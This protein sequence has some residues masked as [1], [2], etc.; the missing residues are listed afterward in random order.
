MIIIANFLIKEG[1]MPLLM[2]KKN[3]QNFQINSELRNNF[4]NIK[5]KRNCGSN[6]NIHIYDN[7]NNI[8]F[9]M[10]EVDAKSPKYNNFKIEEEKEEDNEIETEIEFETKP[11]TF[12]DKN[13][14]QNDL[15][16]KTL[17]DN[18]NEKEEDDLFL[19]IKDI[20]DT[21]EDENNNES[22]KNLSKYNINNN[23]LNQY[24]Y[25]NKFKKAQDLYE[26]NDSSSNL[27]DEIMDDFNIQKEKKFHRQSGRNSTHISNKKKSLL[28]KLRNKSSPKDFYKI[29]KSMFN[30]E[31]FLNSLKKY[32]HNTC[33][34]KLFD[35]IKMPQSKDMEYLEKEHKFLIETKPSKKIDELK[36]GSG[37]YH[38]YIFMIL[39][40]IFSAMILI[41][42]NL[43]LMSIF[44][45]A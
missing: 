12:S 16:F 14:F 42:L 23:K 2:K 20:K 13:A 44:Y 19:D 29:I 17:Y 8:N 36:L 45:N 28:F 43:D 40:F 41:F 18:K 24:E 3:L 22:E 37:E 9:L 25:N 10:G 34:K 32:F 33:N 5:I 39:L 27:D 6:K 30:N 26:D 4:P 21:K 35:K 31:E 15:L 1:K 7:K 38:I 11:R